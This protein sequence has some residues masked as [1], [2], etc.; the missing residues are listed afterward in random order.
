MTGSFRFTSAFASVFF[1]LVVKALGE[2]GLPDWG[3]RSEMQLVQLPQIDGLRMRSRLKDEATVA[4][5][6]KELHELI[7]DGKAKLIAF[8]SNWSVS[9]ERIVSETIEEIRYETEWNP[10]IFPGGFGISIEPSADIQF[11]DALSQ[12]PG[13]DTPT[14]FETR[15]VGVSLELNGTVIE[16][17]RAV[18]ASFVA[19]SVSLL[20][21]RPTFV[22]VKDN[23]SFAQP[24]FRVHRTTTQLELRSGRWYLVAVNVTEGKDPAMEFT[25]MRVTTLPVGK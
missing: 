2:D 7:A 4:S 16:T 9:G 20:T 5:G 17:G 8:S 19:Q 24:I 23:L 12:S 15:N 6:V 1:L 21:M 3:I 18:D 14:G 13:L 10:P 11:L 22:V 25:L